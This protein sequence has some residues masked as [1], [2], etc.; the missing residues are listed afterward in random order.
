M[1]VSSNGR[2]TKNGHASIEQRVALLEAEVERL[3][4]VQSETATDGWESLVGSQAGNPFFEQVVRE[5][6]RERDE[7]Y[8]RARRQMRKPRKTQTKR[9]VAGAK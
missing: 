8:A 5:M 3:K 1:K 7:D 2:H 4:A 9:R 6:K